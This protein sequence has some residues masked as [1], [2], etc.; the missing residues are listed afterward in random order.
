MRVLFVAVE[1]TLEPRHRFLGSVKD[2]RGRIEY[3]FFN[4]TAT[5]EIYT[6]LDEALLEMLGDLDLKDFTHL[7]LNRS[8][9]PR[10]L[11]FVR[12]RGPWIRIAT[13]PNNAEFYHRLHAAM[14][15]VRRTRT[16]IGFVAEAFRRGHLDYSCGRLSDFVLTIGEWERD[17]Y[18]RY[19]ARHA[20]VRN[21]PYFL[22]RAYESEVPRKEKRQRCVCLMS[23]TSTVFSLDTARKFSQFVTG[24]GDEAADWEFAITGDAPLRKIDLPSRVQPTGFLENPFDL[25]AESRA[26]AV[27][28][29][30][31]FGFKTKILDAIAC[32]C[33]VLVGKKLY[34]RLPEMVKPYCLVVDTKSPASIREALRRAGAAY[35]PGNPND[36]LRQQAYAALDEVF[37]ESAREDG[38]P[39][40]RA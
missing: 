13:R 39:R 14:A 16:A 17:R 9:Y 30:Y 5:T 6:H 20:T 22:P 8:V 25:M 28:S 34:S 23:T 11:R 21:V 32:R 7:F 12:D 29:D 26:V 33:Y 37:R 1:S 10:A 36:S 15:S 27:L 18:W 3:F 2:E 38:R 4:D 40:S 19:L 35:T 24:I 31:G